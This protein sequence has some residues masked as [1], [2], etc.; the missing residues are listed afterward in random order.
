VS[1]DQGPEALVRASRAHGVRDARLLK[2]IRAIPRAAF[3]PP[4]HVGRAYVDAPVPIARDQVTT[5]PSLVAAMIDALGIQGDERVLEVGTGL[6]WQT[7]LLAHMARDVVS[8]ERW[9]ELAGAA[10]ENLLRAGIANAEVVVGDGSQ[11][12][13]DGAPYDAILVSAAFPEVPAPLPDQLAETGRLVMP[14]GA[15][16]SEHVVLFGRGPEG[17]RPVRTVTEA[18]FVRLYGE[19]GF[20]AED[21]P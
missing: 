16:G 7:A 19:H 6:G 12:W 17:L 3:V 21:R 8:V 2:A 5:Q 13:P 14:I 15:G 11:G 10:R 4:Q 20:G 9:P 1:P 18:S